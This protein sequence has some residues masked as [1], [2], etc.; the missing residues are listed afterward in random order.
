MDYLN[1]IQKK[2]LKVINNPLELQKDSKELKD[3]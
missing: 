1:N 2:I 3:R